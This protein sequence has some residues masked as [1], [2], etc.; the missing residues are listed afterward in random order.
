MKLLDLVD[1][2]DCFRSIMETEHFE[3]VHDDDEDIPDFIWA[4]QGTFTD[5]S[6][7]T[8][9][10]CFALVHEKYEFIKKIVEGMGDNLTV[11]DI[12]TWEC[13]S[14]CHVYGSNAENSPHR[15]NECGVCP[16]KRT[17]GLPECRDTGYYM[18]RAGLNR[19]DPVNVKR[20]L[21]KVFDTLVKVRR[22][23]ENG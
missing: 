16:V 22:T 9:E 6:K 12:G 17:L 23:I 13:C 8:D 14:F 11:L 10:Q 4:K 5:P 1:M 19:K 18:L 21:E 3:L 7:M 2:F 15:D 20:G